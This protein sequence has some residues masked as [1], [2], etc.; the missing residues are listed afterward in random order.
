VLGDS[1]NRTSFHTLDVNTK[2]IPYDETA[3]VTVTTPTFTKTGAVF[4]AFVTYPEKAVKLY[5]VVEDHMLNDYGAAELIAGVL[6]GT[7]SAMTEV[8]LAGKANPFEISTK[9]KL[10]ISRPVENVAHLFVLLENGK[11]SPLVT[12]ESVTVS[13]R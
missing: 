1:K 11:V 8:D 3:T 4:S 5:Y 13:L 10:N 9:A 2:A 12:S 6:D 7:S